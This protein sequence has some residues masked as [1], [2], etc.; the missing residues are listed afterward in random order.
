MLRGTKAILTYH[1]GRVL[2]VCCV[3]SGWAL[4]NTAVTT[5]GPAFVATVHLTTKG[6][7]KK[8]NF[9]WV[10]HFTAASSS[11]LFSCRRELRRSS[12]YS[13]YLIEFWVTFHRR[14]QWSHSECVRF[15]RTSLK[16]LEVIRDLLQ[17]GRQT[18]PC[19]YSGFISGVI[20]T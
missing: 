14:N 11:L 17:W 20:I 19:G 18:Q 12:S 2:H 10:T 8:G 1:Y 9:Q 3:L 7:K 6:T 13:A 5:I 16:V 4:N 15:G